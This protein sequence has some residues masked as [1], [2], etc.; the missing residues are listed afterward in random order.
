MNK[1]TT[2][3]I[4]PNLSN[5]S[6]AQLDEIIYL[7]QKEQEE[8]VSYR[9]SWLGEH[10]RAFLRHPNAIWVRLGDTV[11]VSLYSR[12]NGVKMAKATPVKGDCFNLNTGI[13]VAFAKAC[14]EP[15]PDFI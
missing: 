12:Y 6:D 3:A 1:K 11:I 9:T 5:F 10:Y 8:R 13:A 14:G 15:I 4:I 7:A 2:T